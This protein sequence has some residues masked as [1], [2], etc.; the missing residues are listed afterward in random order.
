MF[1]FAADEKKE[2][3]VKRERKGEKG[4]GSAQLKD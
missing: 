1:G 3:D 4:G 2:S